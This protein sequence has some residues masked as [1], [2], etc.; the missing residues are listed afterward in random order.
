[1]LLSAIVHPSDAHVTASGDPSHSEESRLE[2]SLQCGVTA[3]TCQ[4]RG[5][6]YTHFHNP[7][8][9]VHTCGHFKESVLSFLGSED[10]VQVLWLTRLLPSEV[11][12]W[13]NAI[14]F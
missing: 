11:S 8:S 14:H 1:M 4:E 7:M 2:S 13:P 12:R 9:L 6:W 5:P 10:P 3:G